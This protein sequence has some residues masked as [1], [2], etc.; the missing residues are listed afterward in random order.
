MRW[1]FLYFSS[2]GGKPGTG[3]SRSRSRTPRQDPQQPDPH[4]QA[5]QGAPAPGI[6][7][8]IVF[9]SRRQWDALVPLGDLVDHLGIHQGGVWGRLLCE[10]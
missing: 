9:A 10:Y 2:G 6:V 3:D 7:N 5:L 4:I 1:L 8:R